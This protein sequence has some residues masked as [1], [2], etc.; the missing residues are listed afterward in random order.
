MKAEI[1]RFLESPALSA[2]TRRAYRGDVTEFCAWLDDRRCTLDEIDVRVLSEYA[3]LVGEFK[4]E[5]AEFLGKF[6]SLSEE[7]VA[8]VS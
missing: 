6:P 8:A 1:E 5:R 7:I 3:A 2:A 4:A